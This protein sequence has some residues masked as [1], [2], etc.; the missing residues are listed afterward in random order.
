M[1]VQEKLDDYTELYSTM[2]INQSALPEVKK[3]ADKIKENNLLRTLAL[4]QV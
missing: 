2:E 3:L 1:N 4:L